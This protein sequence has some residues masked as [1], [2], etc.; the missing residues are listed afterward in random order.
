MLSQHDVG[1]AELVR[2]SGVQAMLL[3]APSLGS[4][5]RPC[6][7]PMRTA[8]ETNSCSLYLVRA[9]QAGGNMGVPEL[10]FQSDEKLAGQGGISKGR[11]EETGWTQQLEGPVREVQVTPGGP[12]LP[13]RPRV[14]HSPDE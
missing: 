7:R 5:L 13:P 11:K 4:A 6:S 3:W 9:A 8:A 12:P 2:E 1:I 14:E 10:L